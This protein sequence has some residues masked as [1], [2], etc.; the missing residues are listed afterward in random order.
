V[1][2]IGELIAEKEIQCGM[3]VRGTNGEMSA[4]ECECSVSWCLMSCTTTGVEGGSGMHAL[5]Q[6]THAHLATFSP[7]AMCPRGQRASMP[8]VGQLSFFH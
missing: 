5:T 7:E 6:D 4:F 1:S 8:N 3:S 2:N